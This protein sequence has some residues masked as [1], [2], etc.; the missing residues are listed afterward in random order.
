MDSAD[1]L[2]RHCLPSRKGN[3]QAWRPDLT[4]QFDQR[5]H[6]VRVERIVVSACDPDA[7]GI[8][9]TRIAE[10]R[11]DQNRGTFP[12]ISGLQGEDLRTASCHVF[13]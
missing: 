2:I 10:G 5:Q 9:A 3:T 13:A 6:G 8:G 12:P 11:I 4:Q 7:D 1:R